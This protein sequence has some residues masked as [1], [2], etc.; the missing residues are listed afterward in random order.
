M[1]YNLSKKQIPIPRR[2]SQKILMQQ[3]KIS[4]LIHLTPLGFLLCSKLWN[5]VCG[6]GQLSAV[7]GKCSFQSSYSAFPLPG[8]TNQRILPRQI[9][10]ERVWLDHEIEKCVTHLITNEEELRNIRSI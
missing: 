5:E 4:Y 1:E 8:W 6:T 3:A 9:K 10:M 7:R 2:R